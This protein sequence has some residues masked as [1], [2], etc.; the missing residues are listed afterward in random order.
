[1]ATT[2]AAVNRARDA[3]LSST[4]TSLL[5]ARVTSTLIL[6]AAQCKVLNR[7]GRCNRQHHIRGLRGPNAEC[8]S[9]SESQS[10]TLAHRRGLPACGSE[11]AQPF[12]PQILVRVWSARGCE[13]IRN[14]K[15]RSVPKKPVSLADCSVCPATRRDEI[16]L[17]RKMSGVR[18]PQRPPKAHVILG[19][20]SPRL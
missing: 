10:R 16:S 19:F 17:T 12:G 14:G 15:Q 7:C 2:T 5:S 4:P 13:M 11:P 9:S 20:P 6:S 18:V 1:M 8:E 3:G